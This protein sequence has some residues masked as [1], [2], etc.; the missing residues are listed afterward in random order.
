MRTWSCACTTSAIQD[1]VQRVQSSLRL[2][3]RRPTWTSASKLAFVHSGTFRVASVDS[4]QVVG[5]RGLSL[6]RIGRRCS[7]HR[8]HTYRRTHHSTSVRP[9]AG[10]TVFLARRAVR[11]FHT[12]PA[13]A[14]ATLLTRLAAG[15]TLLLAQGAIRPFHAR[16]PEPAAA[17][18][19]RFSAGTASVLVARTVGAY[20]ARSA[21]ASAAFLIG[22]AARVALLLARWTVR[23]VFTGTAIATA[24]RAA[25]RSTVRPA[26]PFHASGPFTDA[27]IATWLAVAAAS[28]AD[29]CVRAGSQRA[30]RATHATTARLIE[31]AARLT[32]LRRTVCSLDALPTGAAAARRAHR[33]AVVP[34]R[35]VNAHRAV[36]ADRIVHAARLAG[37][38]TALCTQNRRQLGLRREPEPVGSR[39]VHAGS[40]NLCCHPLLLPPVV[41]DVRLGGDRHVLPGRHEVERSQLTRSHVRRAG[42]LGRRTFRTRVGPPLHR[43]RRLEHEQERLAIQPHGP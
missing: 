43:L 31:T 15:D 42:G 11:P 28:D 16:A 3:L 25:R 8:R 24:T 22:L 4:V 21:E 32:S 38:P 39:H 29:P 1:L 10:D 33:T 19:P 37:R 40:G 41:V 18:L 26:L 36:V 6:Q 17:L 5:S 30:A 20:H 2:R 13:E 12:R 23:A 14:A 34:A 35:I 7:G 9:A 27:S